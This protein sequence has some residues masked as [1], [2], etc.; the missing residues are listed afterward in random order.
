MARKRKGTSTSLIFTSHPNSLTGRKSKATKDD[1]EPLDDD[2]EEVE[3]TSHTEDHE[4]IP[5]D[6]PNTQ[7]LDSASQEHEPRD[8]SSSASA[9]DNNTQEDPKETEQPPPAEPVVPQRTGK[10][11][12]PPGRKNKPAPPREV[13]PLSAGRSLR[14]TT[15]L[16]KSEDQDD[17]DGHDDENDNDDNDDGVAD[18]SVG[19]S[20]PSGASDGSSRKGRAGRFASSRTKTR[21]GPHHTT[22]IPLDSQGNPASVENDELV[23]QPNAKGDA[24][25]TAN[26]ELLG[27]RQYRVRTF[28][29][30][31]RGN[32][33]QYMLSTEPARCMGFRDS[34]LLFQK[35]KRLYKIIATDEEKYDLIERHII[36][37]SYKGRAIGIVT[38]RS[39][40]RE[41]GAKII[42]GGRRVIDDYDEE[43]SRTLGYREGE[44]A[45]PSDRLPPPGVPYNKNQYVAWHGAS[46]VYHQYSSA[47][48]TRSATESMISSYGTHGSGLS[49]GIGLGGAA[50]ESYVKRKKIIITDENWM[51]EHATAA[52]SYNH[53]IWLRRKLMM[54]PQ[55]ESP[56]PVG[57][58][59]AAA[60]PTSILPGAGGGVYEPHTGLFFYPAATQPTRSKTVRVSSR[61]SNSELE[62]IGILKRKREDDEEDDG[63]SERVM[64]SNGGTVFVTHPQLAIETVVE[65]HRPVT[66]VTG[67]RNVPKQIFEGEGVV[68]EEIKKAILEQIH[69]EELA[70]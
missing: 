31:G 33:R 12:R 28:T 55:Q 25:V 47:P 6:D 23:L 9:I 39:V 40:F 35:H 3:E 15:P 37:H 27:G 4:E 64:I 68:S 52:R 60:P 65:L 67:L 45:D 11:G 5:T 32:G 24:K 53:D 16:M 36:P 19:P 57:A 43:V 46:S 13:A 38:A 62:D 14:S 10:R 34:Y 26:G 59:G 58:N 48:V 49:S 7:D 56:S 20:T 66:R 8:T 54:N 29:V 42:V 69:S 70:V 41:F 63:S 50:K 30:N 44:L 22:S 17:E 21:T 2:Q 61:L 51:L 1:G 18:G